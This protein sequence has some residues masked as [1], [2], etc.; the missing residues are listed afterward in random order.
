MLSKI[1]RIA[2]MIL[3][4]KIYSLIKTI[5]EKVNLEKFMCLVLMEK[6]VIQITHLR[7]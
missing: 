3:K 2:N 5:K 7:K 4:L 6:L 1:L